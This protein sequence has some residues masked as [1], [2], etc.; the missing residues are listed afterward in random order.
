[1]SKDNLLLMAN[2][3]IWA[4]AKLVQSLETFTATELHQDCGLF[5]NSIF[6][7]LNHLLLGE[8]YLWYPRFSEGISPSLALNQIIETDDIL[9][10][11]ALKQK[12][13][14]W[15]KFIQQLD[16]A[17]LAGN[18]TYTTTAGQTLNLPYAATLMHVFNHGTHHRGQISAAMTVMGH[19]CPELDLVYMLRE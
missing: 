11:A 19:D 6:G 16:V 1:M 3:N 17:L 15:V 10:L 18:F 4:T 9:L 8:H 2:Y 14:R 13:Q 5:F 12:S 7:T